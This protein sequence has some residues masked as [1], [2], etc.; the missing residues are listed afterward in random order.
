MLACV[1]CSFTAQAAESHIARRCGVNDDRRAARIFAAP[2]ER[3]GWHEYRDVKSIPA[4][5]LNSGSAARLWF[6]E[7]G[8]ALIRFQEP[9]EDFSAFTAYCFDKTGNLF[10]VRYELRTAWGWGFREEGSFANGHLTPEQ[11]EFFSTETGRAISRPEQTSDI[12][13]A[14]NP[15]IFPTK[16]A[17]PFINLLSRSTARENGTN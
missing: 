12:P 5:Q 13:E 9:E 8:N 17:L 11:S 4:L 15:R 16:A 3:G 2:D 7:D 1:F 6:G 14:L 10:Y